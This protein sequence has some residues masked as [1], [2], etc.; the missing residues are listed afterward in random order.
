MGM[1]RDRWNWGLGSR[2]STGRG[3]VAR[4][5]DGN[6]LGGSISRRVAR[7][8]GTRARADGARGARV[9]VY[10]RIRPRA[11]AR[12][13]RAGGG[14]AR[15]EDAAE[16]GRKTPRRETTR[17]EMR[18]AGAWV[19]DS[20]V[21]RVKTTTSVNGVTRAFAVD[22]AFDEN[23]TQREVYKA[24]CAPVLEAVAGGM[25]GCVMAY[26]QTGSGKT[27]SL[28]SDGGDVDGGDGP[29]LVPRIA[30]DCFARAARR[31][32]ARVRGFR[33]RWRRFITNRWKI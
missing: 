10:A 30:A 28:L 31:R 32:Q 6:S 22:G 29:G 7:A 2:R 14:E 13:G 12:G 17:R 4:A 27:Y 11:R 25:R 3:I 20:R 8:R 33:A 9:G 23:A 5:R 19:D 16:T 26:G 24:T 18:D 21:V 15:D 1:G